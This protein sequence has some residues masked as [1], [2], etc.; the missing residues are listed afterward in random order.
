MFCQ[1]CKIT[2]A[3][4]YSFSMLDAKKGYFKF[5]VSVSMAS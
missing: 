3:T 2:N 1:N 5:D 4:R